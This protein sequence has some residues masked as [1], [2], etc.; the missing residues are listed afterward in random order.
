MYQAI[1]QAI[2]KSIMADEYPTKLPT[3]K[4]LMAQYHASRNTIRKAIDVVFRHG[5]LRRVQGSGNFI[6]KQPQD[7][8][9][10]LNLSIG[11]DQSAMVDGGPLVSKVMTFD[12]VTADDQLAQQGNIAVGDEVYRV[13]RLRYLKDVL[14]DLE[15]SY[16]PRA[17]V[18]FLSSDSVQHS[19][20]AFYARRM[21]SRGARQ[22]ITFIKYGS[23]RNRLRCSIVQMVT[24]RCAWKQLTI[25]RM[26]RCSTSRE[27]SSFIQ[28]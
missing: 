20:F 10:V 26:G 3:E 4:V 13:V 12:K 27:R 24:R 11:F 23:T 8:K 2:I 16:F 14:Y 15:E 6:I 21:T 22:K 25:W 9:K 28:I 5:L 1:A 19:I 7:T 18:P 17:V